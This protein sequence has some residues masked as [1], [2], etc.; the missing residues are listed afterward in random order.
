MSGGVVLVFFWEMFLTSVASDRMVSELCFDL[1]GRSGETQ[2]AV[3][4]GDI[5]VGCGCVFLA[6]RPKGCS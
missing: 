1:D 2:A 4:F 5:G 6:Q 3:L